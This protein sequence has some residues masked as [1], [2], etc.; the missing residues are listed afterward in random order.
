MLMEPSVCQKAAE[1]INDKQQNE[2][3][4]RVNSIFKSNIGL[5]LKKVFMTFLTIYTLLIMKKF[6]MFLL[7]YIMKEKN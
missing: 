6:F 3:I 4:K 5:I 2:L 1:K 7:S